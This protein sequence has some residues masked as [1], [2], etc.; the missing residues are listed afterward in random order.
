[1]K[2]ILAA[3][4][5]A[6]LF[7]APS[8]AQLE[9][10]YFFFPDNSVTVLRSDDGKEWMEFR[11]DG[12]S[13]TKTDGSG[14]VESYTVEIS[15]DNITVR[16]QGDNPLTLFRM[17]LPGHPLKWS[18]MLPDGNVKDYSSGIRII[19]TDILPPIE[20]IKVT[21]I[22]SI[23][24]KPQR[25]LAETIYWGREFGLLLVEAADG[26]IFRHQDL[27]GHE[28]K[29]CKWYDPDDVE[30][31]SV[32]YEDL[33]RKP[34]F[35]GMEDSA[36]A[37][38][39]MKNLEYPKEARDANITGEVLLEFTVYPNGSLHNIKVVRSLHPLLDAEA[40]RVV[41]ASPK[42]TPAMKDG[43]AVPVTYTFPVIFQVVRVEGA[44]S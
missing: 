18:N 15:S 33:D 30:Y 2:T 28:Y 21:A 23:D 6:L 16:G 3:I 14:A 39:V 19:E 7:N 40:V 10:E 8:F 41:S 26:T 27:A 38:W 44:G 32:S 43:A 34:Q 11:R 17:P 4:T 36:F 5:A 31:D 22:P 12:D 20:A 1:M 9:T 29:E 42:W 13:L 37:N 35:M 24:G 25:K